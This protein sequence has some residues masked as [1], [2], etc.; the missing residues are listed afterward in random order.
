MSALQF[1]EDLCTRA[2]ALAEGSLTLADLYNKKCAPAAWLSPRFSFTTT[3]THTPR[4]LLSP[5]LPCPCG[6]Q[7][8]F[9]ADAHLRLSHRFSHVPPFAVP[10]P[11][12]RRLYHQLTEAI[13]AFVR[14]PA[15]SQN[16]ELLFH[17]YQ[18]FI[19]DISK[20]VDKLKLSQIAYFVAERQSGIFLFFAPV[21]F[22]YN[23]LSLLF[24]FLCYPIAADAVKMLTE[25]HDKLKSDLQSDI[26]LDAASATFLTQ[27]DQEKTKFYYITHFIFYYFVYLY[28]AYIHMFHLLIYIRENLDKLQSKI[29][30]V[31]GLEPV[32]YAQF[33]NLC[34]KYYEVSYFVSSRRC[35]LFFTC[36]F[37]A[38][39]LRGDFEKYYE[40]GIVYLSYAD[41]DEIA[42][43]QKRQ[44]SQKLAL[45]CLLG[46]SKFNFGELV[47]LRFPF[48]HLSFR[49]VFLL[50][51]TTSCVS[52]Q[53]Q[54][55]I[56]PFI[57]ESDNALYSILET[58]NKG[59]VK[60][61]EK[62]FEES[63]KSIVSF[64]PFCFPSV[65]LL[66]CEY[67]L[68]KRCIFYFIL[69]FVCFLNVIVSQYTGIAFQKS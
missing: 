46:R 69:P 5:R 57:K 8:L 18:T 24:L 65:N 68:A 32:V 62:Q 37:T 22:F 26:Y 64:P 30:S 20:K 11:P 10:F 50:F 29:D 31:T 40:N 59:D 52:I 45:A 3:L 27:I 55:Q 38:V 66:F 4:C 1:L 14:I 21:E 49:S 53:L 17:F 33:Y 28:V 47:F 36:F 51:L 56:A 2:P 13:W 12:I 23:A 42:E 63:G 41:L 43:E 7:T 54:S 44:F 19:L 61:F 60:L 39:Q 35:L 67:F 6:V 9:Y 16:S 48:S 58:F 15:L 25:L 34:L